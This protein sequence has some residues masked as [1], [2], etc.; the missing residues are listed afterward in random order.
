MMSELC[1]P[2]DIDL[3]ATDT[4]DDAG[5]SLAVTDAYDGA[6]ADVFLSEN[7]NDLTRNAAQRLL[8]EGQVTRAGIPLRKNDRLRAG[9]IIT[10][11]IPPPIPCETAAE[12]ISLDIVY[13]DADIIVVNKPRG[14]VVHPAAGHETGTL[15]NALLHHCGAALSGIGGVQRPGIV[16]RLDKDTSGLMVAAKN[17]AAHQ[18]LAAQLSA[19][20]MGRIYH[21]LCIG[22][23][24][25]DSQVVDMPI[26]RH[27]V[28][29]KKMAAFAQHRAGAGLA[30]AGRVS[31]C[32]EWVPGCEP[33]QRGYEPTQMERTS[34]RAGRVS[35]SP[36]YAGK[37][38]DAVTYVTVLERMDRFTLVEARLE[39]G[40]THQIRVHMSYLGYPVLGDPLYGPKKQ[41]FGVQ[42]QV[43]HAKELRLRHPSS[44]VAMEFEARLP[45]YFLAALAKARLVK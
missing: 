37:C 35:P 45:D 31:P 20:E 39:T 14:L 19:R 17:D 4:V 13:E 11:I 25:Q 40:R 5:I 43:L 8:S 1:M 7:I 33:T 21:A 9:D 30:R 6:R 3:L 34:P 16:H 18:A 36:T 22:R 12:A 24:K 10:C 42:G 29:R 23:V 26:G 28:D 32:M 44:G 2:F 15:V 38:R 41:P 27:P